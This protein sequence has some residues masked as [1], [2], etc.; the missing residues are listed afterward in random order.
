MFAEGLPLPVKVTASVPPLMYGAMLFFATGTP[1]VWL[2]I[3]PAVFVLL[4][5]LMSYLDY[6]L[7]YAWP[8]FS[9]VFL[10]TSCVLATMWDISDTSPVPFTHT[11]G[12]LWAGALIGCL[13]LIWGVVAARRTLLAL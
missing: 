11:A 10:L 13:Y 9:G 1:R 12:E 8:A 3:I 6:P 2:G 5:V 7:T 4:F